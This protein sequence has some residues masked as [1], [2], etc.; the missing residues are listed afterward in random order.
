MGMMQEQF[1]ECQGYQNVGRVPMH[2]DGK[3][4]YGLPPMQQTLDRTARVVQIHHCHD[5]FVVSARFFCS[6][7][8]LMDSLNCEYLP[9][10]E[11]ETRLQQCLSG[12]VSDDRESFVLGT[13]SPGMTS[14]NY[15]SKKDLS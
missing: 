11:W 3:V 4:Y 5:H 2:R 6:S 1:P 7:R 15:I 9:L 14:L 13:M 12:S 8:V 10:E